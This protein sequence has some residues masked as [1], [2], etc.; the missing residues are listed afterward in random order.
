MFT[1][2]AC[3]GPWVLHGALSLRSP[4]S[5]ASVFWEGCA[6][7]RSSQMTT[8]PFF[9]TGLNFA[10][11]TDDLMVSAQGNQAAAWIV[12]FVAHF[13]PLLHTDGA[14]QTVEPDAA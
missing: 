2:F 10:L 7:A 14:I 4:L 11:A 13:L 6:G 3:H 8:L 1:P 9:C 5:C 12:E